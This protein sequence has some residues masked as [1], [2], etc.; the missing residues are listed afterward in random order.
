MSYVR[1]KRDE[2]RCEIRWKMEEGF[3]GRGKREDV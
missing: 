2:G 1:G 3:D